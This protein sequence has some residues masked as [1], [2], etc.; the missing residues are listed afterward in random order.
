MSYSVF[1]SLILFSLM[2]LHT[3]EEPPDIDQRFQ[4]RGFQHQIFLF[5]LQ[6]RCFEYWVIG[7]LADNF[8][9]KSKYVS[10]KAKNKNIHHEK[11]VLSRTY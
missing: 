8:S 2:P 6:E 11:L 10:L 3:S 5:C 1:L 9:H 7:Q 4:A